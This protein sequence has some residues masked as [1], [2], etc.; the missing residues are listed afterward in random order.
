MTT[1]V[2]VLRRRSYVGGG[3]WGRNEMGNNLVKSEHI[4]KG[5]GG[6]G[7]ERRWGEERGWEI[8]EK[9]NSEKRGAGMKKRVGSLSKTG[10]I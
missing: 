1:G 3:R 7:R 8:G 5:D 2:T 10:L 9:P 4:E 6:D